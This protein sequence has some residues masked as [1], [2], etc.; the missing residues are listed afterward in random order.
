MKFALLTVEEW[1][2]HEISDYVKALKDHG[3]DIT[4]I[5]NDPCRDR[6]GFSYYPYGTM[7]INT[8][9]ELYNIS[10]IV[11][12]RLVITTSKTPGFDVIH[13]HDG[14]I[15]IYNDWME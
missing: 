13:D 15:L 5:D 14:D 10:E 4:L 8:L 6:H 12:H 2:D 11:G 7:I 3:Y 9:E 1:E